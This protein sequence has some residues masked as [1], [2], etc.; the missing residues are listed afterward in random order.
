MHTPR[1]PKAEKG[2]ELKM[3]AVTLGIFTSSFDILT[4]VLPDPTQRCLGMVIFRIVDW[5]ILGKFWKNVGASMSY[6]RVSNRAKG[7][8]ETRK[9]YLQILTILCKLLNIHMKNSGNLSMCLVPSNE[10]LVIY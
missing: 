7:I 10:K 9:H 3:D 2:K 1:N 6:K 8:G 5:G 4:S